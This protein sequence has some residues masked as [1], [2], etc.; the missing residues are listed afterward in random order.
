[1]TRTTDGPIDL[2]GQWMETIS[3]GSS[4]LLGR[5]SPTWIERRGVERRIGA[6]P[7]SGYEISEPAPAKRG[8][9]TLA[10]VRR[11]DTGAPCGDFWLGT[12]FRDGLSQLD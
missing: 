7:I 2:D 10:G 8:K 6:V 9:R 4:F 3:A 11:A 1:M 12:R 5:P